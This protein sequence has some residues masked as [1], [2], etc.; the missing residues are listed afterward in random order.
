MRHFGLSVSSALQGFQRQRRLPQLQVLLNAAAIS[1]TSRDRETSEW[2]AEMEPR[3]YDKLAEVGLLPIRAKV[4]QFNLECFLDSYIA[5]RSDVKPSTSVVYGH[6]RR[7]F[8][9]YFGP[10]KALADITPADADDWR[11]WLALDQNLSDNTI[12]RRC[13]MLG[14]FSGM[15]FGGG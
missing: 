3:L 9:D 1:K 2:V 12:R 5:R 6:T 13:A 11:R 15:R 4:E 8:V 14:S 7:C 10:T